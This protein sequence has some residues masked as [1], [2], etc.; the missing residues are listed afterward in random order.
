M[1]S[2]VLGGESG[3]LMAGYPCGRSKMPFPYF[4]EVMTGFEYTA[5]VGMLQEGMEAE[6]QRCIEAI[7][8]RYD[9]RK[10]SP[11][12]EAE[13]EPVSGNRHHYGRAMASWA[14][15]LAWTG[16]QWSGV[17]GTMRFA[18]RE[19]KWFWSNGE[20]WG[21]CEQRETVEGMEV[22]L[23]VLYGSLT[24]RRF[25]VTGVRTITLDAA[26]TVREGESVSWDS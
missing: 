15:V 4:N 25:E 5:A 11:F 24:L 26:V 16:F 14:A 17:T 12:D 18:A 23:Q 9:G 8:A 13:C 10:R 21:T 7:R 3:L 6:G 1:C 2:C 22:T 19:G 20:A